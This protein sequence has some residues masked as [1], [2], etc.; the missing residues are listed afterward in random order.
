[1]SQNAVSQS[2]ANGT[3]ATNGANSNNVATTAT[4]NGRM[5]NQNG[6]WWYWTPDNNWMQYNSATRQWTP[7]SRAQALRGQTAAPTR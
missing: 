2:I 3:A 5:V 4:N 1:M 6:Q 7:Y